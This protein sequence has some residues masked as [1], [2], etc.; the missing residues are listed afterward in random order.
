MRSS[1]PRPQTQVVFLPPDPVWAGRALIPNPVGIT[2]RCVRF[3]SGQPGLPHRRDER[4]AFPRDVNLESRRPLNST[5][6][7]RPR[8]AG[9]LHTSAKPAERTCP[10]TAVRARFLEYPLPCFRRYNYLHLPVNQRVV[11]LAHQQIDDA[12]QIFVAERIKK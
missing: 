5:L 3:A 8:R 7:Q 6:D 11:Q 1:R 4:Q 12:K 9:L 2:V 10:I